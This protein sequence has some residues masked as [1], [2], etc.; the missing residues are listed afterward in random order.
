MGMNNHA[1]QGAAGSFDMLGP[2]A[3][4]EECMARLLQ[5]N[6][7]LSYVFMRTVGNKRLKY[8]LIKVS[9]HYQP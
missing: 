8:E 9:R 4:D 2:A 5:T 7:F 3:P 6:V 1:A